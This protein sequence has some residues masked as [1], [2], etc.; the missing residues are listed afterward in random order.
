MDFLA[1]ILQKNQNNVYYN[2]YTA[3]DTL[4]QQKFEGRPKLAGLKTSLELDSM[5]DLCDDSNHIANQLISIIEKALF[6]IDKE[7]KDIK[8]NIRH[9]E[10]TEEINYDIINKEEKATI[11]KAEY[12]R[13]KKLQLDL[14]TLELTMELENWKIKQEYASFELNRIKRIKVEF[15]ELNMNVKKKYQLMMGV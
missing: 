10:I 7:I 8:K 11:S 2:F 3:N 5:L 12:E 13:N 15:E 14:I 1:D 6:V 4:L 9:K